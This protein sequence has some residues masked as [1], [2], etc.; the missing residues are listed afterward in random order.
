MLLKELLKVLGSTRTAGKDR[1]GFTS[2]LLLSVLNVDR[3]TILD[4][5]LMTNY[6]TYDKIQGGMDKKSKAY[7]FRWYAFTY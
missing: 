4:E 5:Y 7:R 6:Y 1:K 3:Q 2:A